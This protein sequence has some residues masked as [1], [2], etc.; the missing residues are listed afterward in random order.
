[1]QNS[2]KFVKEDVKANELKEFCNLP[3]STTSFNQYEKYNSSLKHKARKSNSK[4]EV[5]EWHRNQ[6]MDF[7]INVDFEESA[8]NFYLAIHIS[9]LNYNNYGGSSF[10]LNFEENQFLVSYSIRDYSMVLIMDV[11]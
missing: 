9:D 3:F 5:N 2:H 6:T 7:N 1:M 8:N 11:I 4:L 10:K